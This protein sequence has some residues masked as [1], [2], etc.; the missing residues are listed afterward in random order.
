MFTFSDLGR[1]K[2]LSFSERLVSKG[3]GFCVV[4]VYVSTPITSY[5]HH[6]S[7]R[8][9]STLSLTPSNHDCLKIVSISQSVSSRLNFFVAG[10]MAQSIKWLIIC[11]QGT[12]LPW[13][14]RI[15][16]WNLHRDNQISHQHAPVPYPAMLHSEQKC[17]HF[18]SEWSIVVYGTGVFYFLCI[19]SISYV[20]CCQGAVLDRISVFQ[21]TK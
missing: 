13:N 16:S 4:K 3:V 5:R 14:G 7:Q 2:V 21:F 12:W 17:A 8:M 15:G 19:R 1:P 9:P 11:E 18:C 10:A 6:N 20:S